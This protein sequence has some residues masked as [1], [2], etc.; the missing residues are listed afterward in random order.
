MMHGAAWKHGCHFPQRVLQVAGCERARRL[1]FFDPDLD[2][3]LDPAQPKSRA[4]AGGDPRPLASA[5][6][7]PCPHPSPRGRERPPQARQFRSLPPNWLAHGPHGLEVSLVA[8]SAGAGGAGSVLVPSGTGLGGTSENDSVPHD[9]FLTRRHHGDTTGM[10]TGTASSGLLTRA[11]VT[12]GAANDPDTRRRPGCYT[13]RMVAATPHG[14]PP[15]TVLCQMHLMTGLP[16]L[17][18]GPGLRALP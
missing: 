4:H 6:A 14:L 10:A 9:G 7:S 5:S 15:T 2:R 12:S 1:M 8:A 18:F 16:S 13:H 3:G 11:S 17:A